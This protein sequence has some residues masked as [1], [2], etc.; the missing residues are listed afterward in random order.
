MHTIECILLGLTVHQ[1]ICTYV[2]RFDPTVVTLDKDINNTHIQL[3]VRCKYA[4]LSSAEVVSK[5][6]FSN[7][8]FRIIPSV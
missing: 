5:I 4:F 2:T 7:N 3:F 6:T 8:S 1:Y